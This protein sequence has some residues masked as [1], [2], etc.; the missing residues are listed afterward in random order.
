MILNRHIESQTA[1]HLGLN[2]F[3]KSHFRYKSPYA[4]QL[5]LIIWPAWNIL[6]VLQKGDWKLIEV[7]KDIPFTGEIKKK[8]NNKF[9]DVILWASNFNKTD[10]L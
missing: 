8:G 2:Q 4:S 10:G 5:S 3:V 7:E 6:I 9:C 1:L